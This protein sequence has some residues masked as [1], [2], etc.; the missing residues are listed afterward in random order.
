MINSM[1]C[2]KRLHQVFS[3][4]LW[5]IILVFLFF[6]VIDTM[7]VDLAWAAAVKYQT[8]A[9]PFTSEIQKLLD[10]NSIPVN[11]RHNSAEAL[12]A[13]VKNWRY[14]PVVRNQQLADCGAF[15]PSYYYKTYQEAREHG[16]L[17]PDPEV[18][19]EHVM[20]PGFTYPLNNGGKDTG[21]SVYGVLEGICRY[22]I[23]PWSIMPETHDYLTYPTEVAWRAA[24]PYR[25]HHI[26]TFD[27]KTLAGIDALKEHLAAGDPAV[28]TALLYHD[29]FDKY[30]FQN[31]VGADSDV[32]YGA[33]M[34]LWD[35]H[36]FT[37]IG[38]D[39][40]KSYEVNGETRK[41]AF[42]AV[43]SWGPGWGVYD[44]DVGSGGFVWFAYDYMLEPPGGSMAG[45][46]M[47]L[48]DRIDYNPTDLAVFDVSIGQR[49]TLRMGLRVG[50]P[51]NYLSNS[52]DVFP[53]GGGLHPF[54]GRIVVDVSDLGFSNQL[55]CYDLA[56]KDISTVS[57]ITSGRV[58]GSVTRFQV[59]KSY[60]LQ[61]GSSISSS[62][63][64]IISAGGVYGQ[65]IHVFAG[66]FNSGNIGIEDL[67]TESL[68]ISPCDWDNDGLPDLGIGGGALPN[69][70]MLRFYKNTGQSD[71]SCLVDLTSDTVSLSNSVLA[72]G[73]Y[74][75]DGY[76]DLAVA[77]RLSYDG[78][79]RIY[80]NRNV[81][82]FSD[83]GIILPALTFASLAW[84]DYNND[85]WLDLV[86]AGQD[87]QSKA[88]TRI[89]RNEGG[90]S[91]VDSGILLDQKFRVGVSWSD[92][93]NDGWL[94]L[95]VGATLYQNNTDGTFTK[96]LTIED[97]VDNR[98]AW[99]DFDGDGLLDLAYMGY[100]NSWDGYSGKQ[101]H[102]AIYRNQGGFNFTD[103]NTGLHDVYNGTLA[104][105]DFDN[106][107][108]LDLAL[109]GY[110]AQ[111]Y[112]NK[113]TRIYHQTS[114][115]HFN[116]IGIDLPQ[117]A[118]GTVAWVDMD[119]DGALDLF[120]SGHG[121]T[122]QN[123]STFQGATGFFHSRI[124]L[125]AELNRPNQPPSVPGGLC[126]DWQDSSKTLTLLWNPASDK[127]TTLSLGLGYRLRVG[128]WSG[129]S[130]IVSSVGVPSLYGSHPHCLLAGGQPGRYLVNLPA[131]RYYWS[132]QAIDGGMAS[133]EWSSEKMFVI[134]PN[135]LIS[136]DVNGDGVID[137][138]DVV[139]LTGMVDGQVETQLN[140][141][142]LDGNGEVQSLDVKELLDRL[143]DRGS[144]TYMKVYEGLLVSGGAVSS[145]DYGIELVAPAGSLSAPQKVSLEVSST[146]QSYGPGTEPI[147]WR[148]RGLP[149]DNT[150]PLKLR[151]RDLRE[152]TSS[153]PFLAIG[154]ECFAKSVGE[155]TTAYRVVAGRSLGN[156][157]IE[158][159]LPE[160]GA[161]TDQEQQSMSDKLVRSDGSNN[162]M[163]G[164]KNLA[165]YDFWFVI[166]LLKDSQWRYKGGN[167]I[168]TGPLGKKSELPPLAA[169]LEEA[170]VYYRDTL[171]FNVSRRN[172]TKY[173]LEVTVCDVGGRL[174][175]EG[176]TYPG[177]GYNSISIELNQEIL[178]DRERIRT[179]AAHEL[180]HVV[181]HLMDKRN[182]ISRLVSSPDLWLD[183][184][185]AVY[186]E[187]H[188]AYNPDYIPELLKAYKTVSLK[189]YWQAEKYWGK[190]SQNYGYGSAP[191]IQHLVNLNGGNPDIVRKIYEKIQAGTKGLHAL[192]Q[193]APGYPL[194]RWYSGYFREIVRESLYPG[195][196][197]LSGMRELATKK[198]I[199]TLAGSSEMSAHFPQTEF[200]PLSAGFSFIQFDKT[201]AV[202][203]VESRL[204]FLLRTEEPLRFDLEVLAMTRNGGST[205]VTSL[206][207]AAPTESGNGLKTVIP[208]AASYTK[209]NIWLVPVVTYKHT[210][211]PYDKAVSST[212]HFGVIRDY[213]NHIISTH[214]S[215]DITVYVGAQNLD[216]PTFDGSGIFSAHDVT[217]LVEG[218]KTSSALTMPGLNLNLWGE[219]LQSI[220]I[221]YNAAVKSTDFSSI[222]GDYQVSATYLGNKLF[223]LRKWR[224]SRSG[225]FTLTGGELVYESPWQDLADFTLT[226]DDD[227]DVC[228]FTIEMKYDY[229]LTQVLITNG[230]TVI[231]GDF[232]REDGVFSIFTFRE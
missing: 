83:S 232:T 177:M 25:G 72:W 155:I 140:A 153:P 129:G 210:Y 78:F 224:Y 231:D 20:S 44:A 49:S 211:L 152:D 171:G 75:N 225:A 23:A 170:L 64:C 113:S 174:A 219:P 87:A 80:R 229:H 134:G 190:T 115:A 39:D 114:P 203:T 92:M 47:A 215:G 128:T 31:V 201:F 163:T 100:D 126:V 60:G 117:I 125:P 178:S 88:C 165:N 109:C 149:I 130:D 93:D 173:P 116:D 222:V 42:L 45:P 21:A 36:A 14:L 205:S 182:R 63:P 9:L 95:A 147:S 184:A 150:L 97:G 89:Y 94:D 41:G 106:D 146:D 206:G 230:Q 209:S 223:R 84:G 37:V 3:G 179:T 131:G 67:K 52:I 143:L 185:T 187:S 196:I 139:R 151:V 214:N 217:R 2:Y 161:L 202:P 46:V 6:L 191:L 204:G 51:D 59:E 103:I 195:L 56:I 43:N 50:S 212:L 169:D 11:K 159:D 5:V 26:I 137:V 104:W 70:A 18:D 81:A 68:I 40:N 10:K 199:V 30:G 28:M 71:F 200:Y 65:A 73:D 91:F 127:E 148:A 220:D 48:E 175:G 33:G 107:G 55:V 192:F 123:S 108:L 102:A 85:G 53:H 135:G 110:D 228:L 96:R 218:Y 76:P 24:I 13:K 7:S 188:F 144:G 58:T 66:P 136:G 142:D 4:N 82:G 27:T 176:Y 19:P 119:S 118:S 154:G 197:T 138:A 61:M 111:G 145:P 213:D 186:M 8:G 120:V 167:F 17:H 141:A 160:L 193:C 105:A 158:V 207:Y 226:M 74:D 189:G 221:T 183:E 227:E 90:G 164:P 57:G 22:G 112:N 12:P 15:S 98:Q 29:T 172:W 198:R 35:W 157:W 1:K 79:T 99:G 194:T 122:P 16:W 180:F 77:G 62:D 133:S 124:A 132:V 69:S 38:Y 181:Q 168:V 166:H 121:A 86:V 34:N 208:N 162:R 216:W 101:F 54:E 156:G 32:I